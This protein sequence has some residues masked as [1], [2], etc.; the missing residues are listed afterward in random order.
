[1]LDTSLVESHPLSIFRQEPSPEADQA[2][3]ELGDTRPIPLAREQILAMG[4]DPAEAVRIPDS[5]GLGPETYFGRVDVFHQIH[6][7]DALRREAYWD[8]YYGKQYP[9]GL[10][11]TRLM[12][13]LHLSH[14]IYYLLQNILCNANTAVYPHFWTDTVEYPWPD[15]DIPHQ[16]RDFSAVK[17]WQEEK[18]LNQ[19]DFSNLTKP[20]EYGPPRF[21]SYRF[22]QVNGYYETHED[23]GE[24][25]GGAIA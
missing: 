13:R 25:D 14:C 11:N 9:G 4:K 1:M 10:N 5:W 22:K 7:L 20:E 2:W 16:C 19:H 3:A 17:Q 24:Y 6:C 18:A 8:Y 12:H 21:M 23:P 15:F